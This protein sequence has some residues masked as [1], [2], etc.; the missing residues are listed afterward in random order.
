MELKEEIAQVIALNK[1]ICDWKSWEAV[2]Q[3]QVVFME[4]SN[5]ILSKVIS[6]IQSI[7]LTDEEFKDELKKYDLPQ[8]ID[9]EPEVIELTKM[10]LGICR[11][12]MKAK[13][14]QELEK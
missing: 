8:D 13:I 11:K 14:I 6:K 5:E 4:L 7:E 10:L 1:K 2:G 9:V 12:A 3:H